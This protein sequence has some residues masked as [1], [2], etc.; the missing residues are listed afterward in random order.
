VVEEHITFGVTRE[1]SSGNELSV[2]FMY[3]PE[4]SVT[5]PNNF[6]PTQDITIEMEQFELEFGYSW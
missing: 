6:D 3:A 5:G 1:S 2:S 4:K